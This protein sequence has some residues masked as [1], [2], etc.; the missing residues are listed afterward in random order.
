M[1]RKGIILAGGYGTR[2]YPIN[3]AVSKHLL[4]IYD[5][6]LIYYS[7]TTLMLA[8]IRDILIICT[9]K[10]ESLYKQILGDGSNFGVEFIL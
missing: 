6:P 3:S 7:I 5:K 4:P 1:N 8:N 9:I 2:M 10:D